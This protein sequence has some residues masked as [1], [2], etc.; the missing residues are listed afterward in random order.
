MMT[1][2]LPFTVVT[3]APNAHLLRSRKKRR[4]MLAKEMLSTLGYPVHSRSA[5]DLGAVPG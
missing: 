3:L 5:N 4:F 2:F 1:I